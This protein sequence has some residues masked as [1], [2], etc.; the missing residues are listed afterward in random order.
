MESLDSFHNF[1]WDFAGIAAATWLMSSSVFDAAKVVGQSAG[2][3]AAH[4]RLNAAL[5]NRDD[6]C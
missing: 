3:F 4:L 2:C 1:S 6:E 5:V